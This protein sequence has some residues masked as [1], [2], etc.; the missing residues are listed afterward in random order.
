[1]A[2][3]LRPINP[4]PP[5]PSTTPRMYAGSGSIKGATF[6]PSTGFFDPD[7]VRGNSVAINQGEMNPDGLSE[8][9]KEFLRK[10]NQIWYDHFADQDPADDFADAADRQEIGQEIRRLYDVFD[11]YVNGKISRE[12][13]EN[14]FNYPNKDLNAV[15][16]FQDWF[17]E[18]ANYVSGG[19]D[20]E[21]PDEFQGLY[22]KYG[23]DVVDDAREKYDEVVKVL[24]EAAEDP[25]GAIEDLINTVS[26][27]TS[28]CREANVP[29][30]IRNCVTVGVLYGIPGLPLPPIP[31]VMGTTIGELEEGFKNIGRNVQDILDGAETCGEDTDGDGVGNELCTWGEAVG[32][33]KDWVIEKAGDAV[34]DITNPD[35]I[36]DWITG[37][38]GPA[39]GGLIFTEVG[40]QISD[41]LFPVADINDDDTTKTCNDPGAVNYGE[42]GECKYT[43]EDT[44]CDDPEATNFGQEGECK[45]ADQPT[46]C[47][48][49]EA[50]NFGQEG[51]C[52]YA[53]QP[54]VCDDPEA[55]NFGQEGECKYADQPTICEDPEATNTGEEGECQ[56][57][58]VDDTRPSGSIDELCSQPRPEQYGFGQINWDKYCSGGGDIVDDGQGLDCQNNPEAT[59]LECGWVEC[60]EGGFAPTEE[61][62]GTD[63]EVTLGPVPA[64][65]GGGGG[66]GGGGGS[67][68][69][70][71]VRGLSYQAQ[72]VPGLMS[73]APVNA[74]A[75]LDSFISRQLQKRGRM[76]T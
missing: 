61:E 34:D 13:F 64:S 42:D 32:R 52:Q 6:E 1:M 72:A 67:G 15:P 68:F 31:G 16:G 62:C 26:S 41:I 49:P 25:F 70:G 71:D 59:P 44:V 12:Q 65:S 2:E 36:S 39:L 7:T 3:E 63:A 76:L 35:D 40:D 51:E 27:G 17:N 48:D 21:T 45:Y 10:L 4:N 5:R 66:G 28:E 54:T 46:V 20:E 47:D 11:A 58:S 9:D 22:D 43:F 14:E 73:G 23:K 19:T 30:W 75:E 50:T 18:A 55:T 57:A 60:P 37:I 33:L 29:D 53:D 38:L 69:E 8:R 74:V 24:G 56:Y